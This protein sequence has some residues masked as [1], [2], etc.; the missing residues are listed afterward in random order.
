MQAILDQFLAFAKSKDPHEKYNY[1][2]GEKCA[3]A[4]FA[5]H[6]GLTYRRYDR[7]DH[8]YVIH[9]L[10]IETERVASEAASGIFDHPHTWGGIVSR[11]EARR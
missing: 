11:L 6:I 2:D 4:Q 10:L 3:N 1:G 8:S 5:R 7:E 9:P